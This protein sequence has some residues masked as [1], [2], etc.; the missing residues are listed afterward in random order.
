MYAKTPAAGV[1]VAAGVAVAVGDGTTMVS[2][3][4]GVA[5]LQQALAPGVDSQWRVSPEGQVRGF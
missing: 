5:Q 2:V 3:A 1:P 4:V